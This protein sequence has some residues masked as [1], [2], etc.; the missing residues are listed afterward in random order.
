MLAA[1]SVLPHGLKL[2]TARAQV[3][4]PPI[5]YPYCMYERGGSV[6]N[7]S[8]DGVY[9]IY[10]DNRNYQ[11]TDGPLVTV[12]DRTTLWR[13]M[14]RLFVRM[15]YDYD[16]FW[17]FLAHS[18][19]QLVLPT[20]DADVYMAGGWLGR[21]GEMHHG[22]DMERAGDAQ[23]FR[24]TAAARGDQI[25]WRSSHGR[26][27]LAHPSADDPTFL[28]M[29]GHLDPTAAETA[30]P[31]L[32]GQTFEVGRTFEVG[33]VVGMAGTT[34]GATAIHLHFGFAVP[35]TVASNWT[36]D[37]GSWP[38]GDPTPDWLGT[39]SRRTAFRHTEWYLIDPFGVYDALQQEVPPES[40][41][42]VG[43]PGR[44]SFSFYYPTESSVRT[45]AFAAEVPYLAASEGLRENLPVGPLTAAEM[46]ATFA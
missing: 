12:A 44:Y 5:E 40:G 13:N 6:Y 39:P 9:E 38:F 15:N 35:H 43:V 8:R 37:V 32:N 21:G 10:D 3:I 1:A 18:V 41:N 27:T 42:F 20:D 28:T 7:E 26:V 36:P 16:E 22:I 17:D 29:Y 25:S 24:V 30:V 45:N 11:I 23:T 4:L 46:A 14:P 33:D 34:G 2:A 31:P 19:Q